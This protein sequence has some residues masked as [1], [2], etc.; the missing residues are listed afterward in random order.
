MNGVFQI[1]VDFDFNDAVTGDPI[2]DIHFGCKDLDVVGRS[3][4]LPHVYLSSRTT[5]DAGTQL[6]L[7]GCTTKPI[8]LNISSLTD[9]PT[10]IEIGYET[11]NKVRVE[12]KPL[13]TP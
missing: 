12:L 7:S 1:R 11:P 9:E 2:S 4:E 3:M 13:T 5:P 8:Q 6:S 10:E